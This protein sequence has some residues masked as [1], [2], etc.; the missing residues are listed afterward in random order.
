MKQVLIV[1]DEP[2]IVSIVETLLEANGYDT[3][4]AGDVQEA[5]QVLA[6]R[7]PDLI[8]LDVMM[9][10]VTGW[11]FCKQLKADPAYRDIPVIFVTVMNNPE[12]AKKGLE[13]GAADYIGKPFDP[14]KLVASI[15]KVLGNG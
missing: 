1:D 15:K 11:D 7:R 5:E 6:R 3:F 2:T 4:S 8:L 9:P 14:S 10:K 12:D 13:L